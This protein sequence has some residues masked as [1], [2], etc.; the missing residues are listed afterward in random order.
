MNPS[1]P[2]L[3]YKSIGLF[4]TTMGKMRNQVRRWARSVKWLTFEGKI[5]RVSRSCRILGLIFGVMSI[6]DYITKNK[7]L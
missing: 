7:M 1:C 4:S 2:S 6:F 3:Q 5:G